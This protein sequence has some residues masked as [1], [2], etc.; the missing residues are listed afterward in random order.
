MASYRQAY[1]HL[2]V[3][4][5]DIDKFSLYDALN[6]AMALLQIPEDGDLF[7][8][9]IEVTNIDDQRMDERVLLSR[10]NAAAGLPGP[11]LYEL[12]LY[13]SYTLW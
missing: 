8:I 6:A 9:P 10:R 11:Q 1:Y 7:L 12:G 4:C 5:E 3:F 13:D 2:E